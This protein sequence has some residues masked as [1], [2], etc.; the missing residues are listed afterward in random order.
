MCLITTHT[1]CCHLTIQAHCTLCWQSNFLPCLTWWKGACSI[2]TLCNKKITISRLPNGSIYRQSFARRVKSGVYSGTKTVTLP[3]ER[4]TKG[5]HLLVPHYLSPSKTPAFS[6]ELPA[7]KLSSGGLQQTRQL[8]KCGAQR[9]H[10]FRLVSEKWGQWLLYAST[11]MLYHTYWNIRKHTSEL[12]LNRIILSV[13][14]SISWEP[15]NQPEGCGS[16][17]D[18][19]C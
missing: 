19:E 7:C 5:I 13:P 11:V 14:G 17:S 18:W 1:A 6:W 15:I 2:Q 8:W 10:S 3:K 9:P 12:P 4:S 16:V